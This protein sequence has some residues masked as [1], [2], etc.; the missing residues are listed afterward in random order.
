MYPCII[1][2]GMISPGLLVSIVGIYFLVLIVISLK[3]GK[4][5]TNASF[6]VA[7]RKSPWFAVAFGMIGASLS[8]VTFISVPGEVGASN[9]AYFQIVLGYILGYFVIANV[10]MPVYYRMNLTSIYVY[11]RERFGFVSYRTGAS[12]FLLSRVIGASFRMYLVALVLHSFILANWGI[13]FWLS[14]AITIAF[15]WIYS[16]KGGIKTI[17]WTDVFQTIFLIGAVVFSI[18]F[19]AQQLN[20]SFSELVSSIEES[21]YSQIFVWDWK[22]K[23]NFF[24]YFFSGAFITIVM[25]GLDQDMMQKNLTCKN[26]HEAKKNMY[27]MSSILV[28]VNLIF[29]S[30]GALLYIYCNSKGLIVENFSDPDV[31]ASCKIALM[32]PASSQLECSP[33][34]K[35]FPYLALQQLPVIASIAFLLGL[36]AANYASADSA[37]TALTTSFCVDFLDFS[38]EKERYVKYYSIIFRRQ[39]KI[40]VRHLV[41]ISFSLLILIVI[42]LFKALNNDSVINSLFNIA[43]YTYGPLL[44][45]YSFGLFTKKEIKDKW[46]PYVAILS[47]I[48]CYV[49]SSNS[50]K[51]LGGYKFGFEILILNGFLTFIG[52]WILQKKKAN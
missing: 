15:I 36:I 19:I 2:K 27:T 42:L 31:Q 7:N 9:F 6:F 39:L 34:D 32:N 50:T 40:N 47:P 23:S 43:G 49:I 18:F 5:A 24:K 41:H 20:F 25:T 3:T 33:T 28:F 12:F 10:L 44:G 14:V 35:L 38:S 22:P 29:L 4:D 45:L 51:L 1:K 8:G 11:L 17:V 16:F 48:I 37:L 21:R 46:T 52:L 26:I 30:L 13:P